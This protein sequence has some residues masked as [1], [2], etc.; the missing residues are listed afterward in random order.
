VGGSYNMQQIFLDGGI[1]GYARPMLYYKSYITHPN[2]TNSREIV[3]Y[4]LKVI[5]HCEKYEDLKS[6]LSAFSVGCSTFFN[7]KARLKQGRGKLESLAPTTTAPHTKRRRSNYPFHIEQILILRSGDQENLG[8]AKLKPM[9]DKICI[10]AG[11]KT[12]SESTIGRLISDLKKAG[13]FSKKLKLR[14]HAISGKLHEVKQKPKIQKQR[15][16]GYIPKKAG[17]LVQ[18]D[19]V[20]K[21][22]GGTRRYI[23]SGID[24]KTYFAYS[25]AYK[26]LTSANTRE[27]FLKLQAVAPFTIIHV[28]TDNGAEFHKEFIKELDYQKLVHFWNY[29]RRPKSNGKIERY[30]R[31]IQEEFV[32]YHLEELRDDVTGF[33][34]ILTDWLLYYNTKRPH[35]AH[36]EK[37]PSR[38]TGIQIPPLRAFLV[39]LKLEPMESNMLWTQTATRKYS[40]NSIK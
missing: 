39:M 21:F 22:I 9:L 3:D 18:V 23:I 16:S 27:F 36:I 26:S 28:Q 29:P 25:Y 14:I 11:Q 5:Q 1:K 32:D 38:K 4:R 7:W 15:R 33:N 20:E 37:Q 30:N 31:T 2:Y 13:R 24:Y 19:C 10:K 6:T 34:N 12:I 8:K 35:A 40:P 17:D